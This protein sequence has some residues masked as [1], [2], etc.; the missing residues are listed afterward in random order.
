MVAVFTS[1]AF[2]INH[3]LG[4]SSMN[5]NRNE[6]NFH[7]IFHS[8]SKC[9]PKEIS[10]KSKMIYFEII[11]TASIP[12]V[13]L[14]SLLFRYLVKI[15]LKMSPLEKSKEIMAVF[16]F[17]PIFI[18]GFIRLL[19]TIIHIFYTPSSFPP[20][21]I[22]SFWIFCATSFIF[23]IAIPVSFLL[24]N[25]KIGAKIFKK[26][27]LGDTANQIYIQPSVYEDERDIE[28]SVISYV[29]R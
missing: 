15:S 13:F 2:L 12:V 16:Q 4:A 6:C 17:L 3:F 25:T 9:T 11:N 14:Y 23:S 7:M 29:K 5:K 28:I 1:V 22:L 19:F 10:D 8:N 20:F 24:T 21:D 18:Y 26:D 27:F